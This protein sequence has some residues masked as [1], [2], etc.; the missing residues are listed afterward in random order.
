MKQKSIRV[1]LEPE[2]FEKSRTFFHAFECP[3]S[4]AL[5]RHFNIKRA[6][7]CLEKAFI[8]KHSFIIKDGFYSDDYY[9]VK[10]QYSNS[11]HNTRYYLT[12]IPTT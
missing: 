5:K 12:L 11:N 7:V 4:F 6:A 1:F 10:E 8:P 3:G 9:W 2:D